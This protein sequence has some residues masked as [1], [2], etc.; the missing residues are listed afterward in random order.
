MT[1]KLNID[2]YENVSLPPNTNGNNVSNSVDAA[3]IGAYNPNGQNVPSSDVAYIQNQMDPLNGQAP[4]IQNATNEM[5]IPGTGEVYRAGGTSGQLTG[6]RDILLPSSYQIPFAALEQRRY[7]QQEAAKKRADDLGKFKLQKSKLSKDPRF[8]RN[9]VKTYN[10]YTDIFIKEAEKQYGSKQAAMAALTDPSTKIGREYA[11]QVDSLDILAGEVDQIVNLSAK[12]DSAIEKGDRYVSPITAKH[13]QDFKQLIGNFEDGVVAPGMRN[14]L[15][16][17]SLSVGLDSYIKDMGILEGI[18]AKV[19][20]TATVSD[21]GDYYQTTTQKNKTY[22][23]ATRAAAK[24]MRSAFPQMTE[25]EIYNHL[26]SLKGL[27]DIESETMAQKRKGDGGI[28]PNDVQVSNEEQVINIKND[29]GTSSE[30]NFIVEKSI[31]LPISIKSKPVKF[32]G[33]T[34]IQ[35]DGTLKTLPGVQN[36]VLGALKVMTDANGVK[37]RVITG[38]VVSMTFEGKPIYRDV[39]LSAEGLLGGIANVSKE[40]QTFVDVFEKE[41]AN[42]TQRK[43]EYGDLQ[44][45]FIDEFSP[46]MRDI[47]LRFVNSGLEYNEFDKFRIQ[48]AQ[49]GNDIILTDDAI[50]EFKNTLKKESFDAARKR[51]SKKFIDPITSPETKKQEELRN[52]YDY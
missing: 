30:K 43:Q 29:D 44:K 1:E 31:D 23:E 42:I 50:K 4:A 37:R 52:K 25:D 45:N 39:I 9:L 21:K 49:K 34:E 5:F 10:D 24:S 36:V 7:A 33:L 48:E 6:S 26:L 19:T 28:K 32:N 16:E 12:I 18:D 46:K 17:M 13:N 8:N 2:D 41:T 35:P 14:K 15:N 51:V 27:E 22:E 47:A 40:A 3:T 38:Q 20:Q 11:E